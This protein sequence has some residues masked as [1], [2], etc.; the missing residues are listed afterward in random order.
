MTPCKTAI[1]K[2]WNLFNQPYGVH[3]VSVVIDSLGG[4]HTHAHT[5]TQKRT[6]IYTHKHA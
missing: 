2:N 3:I 5:Y 6:H 1:Q 4:G